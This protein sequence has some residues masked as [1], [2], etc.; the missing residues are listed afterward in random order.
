MNLTA[1]QIAK[2]TAIVKG[3]DGYKRAATKSA[4]EGRFRT[5]LGEKI[6]KAAAAEGDT[7]LGAASFEEAAETLR[8]AIEMAA[9][10]ERRDQKLMAARA[11]VSPGLARLR[12]S[13]KAEEIRKGVLEDSEAALA[14]L[15]GK[16]K[17]RAAIEVAAEAAPQPEPKKKRER[18]ARADRRRRRCSR[19]H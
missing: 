6:G 19:P 3:E 1:T 5:A 10:F 9:A 2:L 17:A 16:R 8:T 18:K 11:E 7:I 12:R 14:G 15:N 13:P 4:A